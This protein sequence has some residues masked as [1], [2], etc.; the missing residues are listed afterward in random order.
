MNKDDERVLLDRV[1]KLEDASSAFRFRAFIRQWSGP[2]GGILAVVAGL[3]AGLH[4]FVQPDISG[5][6]RDVAAIRG[7]ITR[8]DATIARNDEKSK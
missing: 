8:M 6:L 4:Y 2:A 7:D 3:I 1:E 5:L